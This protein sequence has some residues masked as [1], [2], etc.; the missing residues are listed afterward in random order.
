MVIMMKSIV[1]EE[2]N[3]FKSMVKIEMVYYVILHIL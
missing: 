1:R 2:Y 3:S